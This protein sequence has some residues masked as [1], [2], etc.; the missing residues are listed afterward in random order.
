MG[1]SSSTMI[2]T[3]DALAYA[4]MKNI[5]TSDDELSD[6]SNRVLGKNQ[7]STGDVESNTKA[8]VTLDK[9]LNKTQIKRA[10]CKNSKNINVRI[11]LPKDVKPTKDEKGKLITKYGYYDKTLENLPIDKPG[12]CT[13]DGIDYS[14]SKKDNVECDDF[15]N[16]YCQNVVKEFKNG[17]DG[18]FDDIQFL[19]Y[20]GE[21]ACY[22][23][24]PEWLKEAWK[25]EPTPK[26]VFPGCGEN[27]QSYLDPQSRSQSGQCSQTI[28]SSI[29]NMNDIEQ[30]QNSNVVN[31]VKQECGKQ[32]KDPFAGKPTG[33]PST[34]G[35]TSSTPAPVGQTPSSSGTPSST[36]GTSGTPATQGTSVTPATQ[37]TQ[38]TQG[39]PS[40]SR[41]YA[42]TSTTSSQPYVIGGGSI[43]LSCSCCLFI[44]IMIIIAMSMSPK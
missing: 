31:Q 44:I 6:L 4:S 5:M 33:T 43:V 34:P 27:T 1:G 28:C 40:S 30:G 14:N 2:P 37:T 20:K 29:I 35:G 22:Q 9:I 10:C 23:P 16:V 26:C 36:Q 21:C 38:A 19:N 8:K 18:K 17:N 3:L 13:V 32:G 12:A 39:T 24:T 41:T 11:P 15:Y 42:A 25:S 7:F